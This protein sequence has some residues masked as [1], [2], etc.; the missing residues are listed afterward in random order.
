[1]KKTAFRPATFYREMFSQWDDAKLNDFVTRL[2]SLYG[3][4]S[5]KRCD[6]ARALAVARVALA[7][8]QRSK[9]EIK[10]AA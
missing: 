7:L 1:M 3:R 9:A 5:E 2:H 6:I 8:R 10:Q 4:T